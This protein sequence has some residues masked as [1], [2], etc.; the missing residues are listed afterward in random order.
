MEFE[1]E[2]IGI[3]EANWLTPMKVRELRLTTTQCYINLDYIKQ[4]IEITASKFGRID[5]SN[6][7]NPPPQNK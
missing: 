6:L 2:S 7:Y 4:E 3:C 1:D 5:E